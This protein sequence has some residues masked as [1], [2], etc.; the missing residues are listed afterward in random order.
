MTNQC[1]AVGCRN[2]AAIGALKQLHFE[3][4]F[5]VLDQLGCSGLRD[6]QF[7]SRMLDAA[8]LSDGNQQ[9]KLSQL[10]PRNSAV[11]DAGVT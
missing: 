6:L 4:E 9:P 3:I 5:K 8:E 10:E 11:D 7:A 2:D 1:V